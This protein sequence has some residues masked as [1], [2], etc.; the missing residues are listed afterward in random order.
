LLWLEPDLQLASQ[1]DFHGC[2]NQET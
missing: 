1:S 2:I